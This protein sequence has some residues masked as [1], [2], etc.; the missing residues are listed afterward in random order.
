MLVDHHCHLDFPELR[1]RPRRGH[2]AR[3]GGGRRRHGDHLDAH[4][5]ASTELLDIADAHDN[6]YCSVGTHPHNAHE[7]LRHPG[8]RDRAPQPSIRRW[9]PSAKPGSTTTTQQSTP[10]AQAEGF[11]QPHRGGARDRPAARDPHAR[12]RRRHAR[13]PR[14]RARQGRR[15][16]AILHCYT[17]GAELARRGCR[18]GPLRVVHRHHHFQEVGGA[19]RHRARRAA[20]PAAGRDGRAVPGARALPRQDATSR[21]TSCTRRRR[22]PR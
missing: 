15:F 20:R 3:Q 14:G 1:R 18:A 19:A 11:R 21:P 12:S 22:S 13:H 16:P 6:I 8:R 9:S 2:R 5:P 17:G 4:P 7:E 10:E